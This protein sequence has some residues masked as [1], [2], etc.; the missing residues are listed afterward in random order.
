MKLTSEMIKSKAAE[1]G[2]DDIGIANIGRYS[3]APPMM[4]PKNYFPNAKSVIVTVQRIPRGTYRGIEEGTHWHNYTF[5]AYNKLNTIFRPR[6]TYAMACF[7]EDHGWEAVPHYP[8]VPERGPSKEPVAPGK[9]FSDIVTNIR[10][11]AVGAGLGE[12]GHA[13][14]FLSRKFGPRVRLGSI[15][16]DAEL[17]PD[18]I[19]PPGTICN[20]CGRCVKE[21]TGNAV[22][23]I[24][25]KDK[26]ITVKIGGVDISWADVD[27]GRCTLTHHG[28]NNTI[29]PFLK[30]DLPN[31]ELDV[32]KAEMTEE[33]AY[34]LT[35]PVAGANWTASPY[36]EH[37]SAVIKYYKYVMNHTG[38][39]AVCGARGC[40]RA[41]MDNLEKNN[42]IKNNFKN[43]FYKKPSWVLPCEKEKKQGVI[44]P[45][46]EKWLVENHPEIIKG[47]QGY[48]E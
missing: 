38:Y 6:L 21:C 35:Y 12:M 3:E 46:R 43:P 33:E 16:T 29:S 17:E 10:L 41:C 48:E 8:G 28:L 45:F 31:F 34:R 44:N 1:L 7:I 18:P 2:L 23:E 40:I 36:D 32:S 26:L 39:F 24:K 30:K 15:I 5:Y 9:P 11:M 37:S 4:D 19:I 13:K 27:M 20:K 42:K 25:D 22:P 47:E 14:V